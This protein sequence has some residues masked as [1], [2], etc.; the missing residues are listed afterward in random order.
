MEMVD[1]KVDVKKIDL[2]DNDNDYDADDETMED[3]ET[4]KKKI[5]NFLNFMSMEYD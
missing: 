3:E 4:L 2:N 1:V 5:S